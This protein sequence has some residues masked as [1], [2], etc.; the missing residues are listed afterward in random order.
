MWCDC[1]GRQALILILNAHSAYLSLPCEEQ[2]AASSR[3]DLSKSLPGEIPLRVKT[4]LDSLHAT[5]QHCLFFNTQLSRGFSFSETLAI[6]PVTN[7]C[8]FFEN[9]LKGRS[10]NYFKTSISFFQLFCSFIGSSTS[11]PTNFPGFDTQQIQ[12]CYDNF[13]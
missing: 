6:L 7:C 4:R 12:Q 13:S 10:T 2:Q 1:A 3:Q 9:V 11:S 8:Y 5:D